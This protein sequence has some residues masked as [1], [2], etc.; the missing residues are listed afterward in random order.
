MCHCPDFFQIWRYTG[1]K[2]NPPPPPLQEHHAICAR[3]LF[4]ENKGAAE[5]K[6]LKLKGTSAVPVTNRTVAN[7]YYQTDIEAAISEHERAGIQ[8]H[9]LKTS[10]R[11]ACS[12][13]LVPRSKSN[14]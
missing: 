12:S 6:T 4:P 3:C 8:D 10:E 14:K 9:Y 2:T 1:K 13:R 7:V 11:A 5:E